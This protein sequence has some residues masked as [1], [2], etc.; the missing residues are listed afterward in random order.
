MQAMGAV[1]SHLSARVLAVLREDKPY[2]LRDIDGRLV[3]R[4]EAKKII[5]MKYQ[6]PEEIRRERRHR[7]TPG[8]YQLQ[9][10]LREMLVP[11]ANEA[12]K[13]PQPVAT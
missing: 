11:R 13:A 1:M 10:K 3:S 9:K 4:E 6:V 7:K 8:N 2:E 12:A 5:L